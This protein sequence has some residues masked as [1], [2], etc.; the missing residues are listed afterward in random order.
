MSDEAKLQKEA[1]HTLK[2][3]SRTFYIPIKLLKPTLKKTVG[4]AYLC[5]RAIDEIEDDEQLS[6]KTKSD[7]LRKTSDLLKES[8]FNDEAYQKLLEPYASI[9][10]D[11]TKRLGDWIRFCPN[12][13]VDK[14]KESTSVMADGMADWAEKNWQVKTKEDLDDY[15][16]YVAGLVGVMLSDIWE[17]YDGTKTDRELAIGYGRGLQ[18]VNVL[19][20]QDEDAERGVQFFPANW[21]REEMFL[22]AEGNLQ[23]AD[24]YLK[25]IQTKTILTFCKIPLALAHRTLKALK[26]GKEKISRREVEET[27]E[28]IIND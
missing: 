14:V 19:R 20:N 8:S 13:V 18:A 16:Y 10:P 23:K 6:N 12:G 28:E 26:S 11:V 7:L 24:E 2:L 17:W 15:T 22:Y 5:M 3:T 27:V 9:L 21:S 25:D 4:S 1:M